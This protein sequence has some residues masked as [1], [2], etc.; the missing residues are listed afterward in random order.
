MTGEPNYLIAGCAAAVAIAAV[1]V[2]VVWND[3]NA[4]DTAAVVSPTTDQ[5]TSTTVY[6]PNE[7]T[8]PVDEVVSEDGTWFI[9]K[10]MKRGRYTTEGGNTCY[11]A[12]L[13]PSKSG[14]LVA[15]KQKM[16]PGPQVVELGKDDVAF[17]TGGCA[18]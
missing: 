5:V 15:V 8:R 2:A 6:K 1:G 9:G 13:V 14:R 12:R 16:W 3:A 4:A 7:V 18:P 10:D 11:W 17:T